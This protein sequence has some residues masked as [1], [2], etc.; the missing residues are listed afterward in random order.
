MM[1][2]KFNSLEPCNHQCPKAPRAQSLCC[3]KLM[4]TFGSHLPKMLFNI[5]HETA[6]SP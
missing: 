5:L 4:R 3:L 2:L 6:H 1:I